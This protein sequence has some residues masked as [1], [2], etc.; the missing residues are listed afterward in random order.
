LKSQVLSEEQNDKL[1]NDEQRSLIITGAFLQIKCEI[2]K[3]Y[4]G[5]FNKA[6]SFIKKNDPTNSE[7][8]NNIDQTIGISTDNP[9]DEDTKNEAIKTYNQFVGIIE[10]VKK[11]HEEVKPSNQPKLIKVNTN[12]NDH[13]YIYDNYEK[14]VEN[15]HA[16]E[17]MDTAEE[18]QR[19]KQFIAIQAFQPAIR[20]FDQSTLKHVNTIEK[21]SDPKLKTGDLVELAKGQK[22]K[23]KKIEDNSEETA[24][25]TGLTRPA[26]KNGEVV[27]LQEK[28]QKLLYAQAN[29]FFNHVQKKLE[30]KVALK[31]VKPESKPIDPNV[32]K[33]QRR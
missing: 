32:V 14:L 20:S 23:N 7:L 33:F 27:V 15:N 1:L 21:K 22:S 6:L 26:D 4:S 29:H 5:K 28:D 8:Y 13:L 17:L 9:M 11:F 25:M 2:E 19:Y 12:V 30:S 18:K 24:Y 16:D 3:E 31:H 10:H